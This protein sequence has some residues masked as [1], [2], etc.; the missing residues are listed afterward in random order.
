MQER[1]AGRAIHL[2]L[3]LGALG[4]AKEKTDLQDCD[5]LE[6]GA[7]YVRSWVYNS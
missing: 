5:C 7:L 1:R 2:G 6:V 4:E 3:S